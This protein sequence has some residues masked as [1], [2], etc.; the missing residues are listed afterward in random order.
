M[1]NQHGPGQVK[2]GLGDSNLFAERFFEKSL[3]HDFICLY[4]Y[5]CICII[6]FYI[7]IVIL[8]GYTRRWLDTVQKYPY[9]MIW[10]G[11]YCDET[12]WLQYMY[13]FFV[14][15]QIHNMYICVYTYLYTQ[16]YSP[17]AWWWRLVVYYIGISKPPTERPINARTQIMK[18]YHDAIQGVLCCLQKIRRRR[19][20]LRTVR[21]SCVVAQGLI[22]QSRANHALVKYIFCTQSWS[23]GTRHP[24]RTKTPHRDRLRLSQMSLVQRRCVVWWNHTFQISKPQQKCG[25]KKSNSWQLPL[26]YILCIYIY[27][28]LF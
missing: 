9:N 24:W 16:H 1:E 11:L 10:Y 5:V 25:V 26:V 14:C 15:I 17:C 6:Y 28:D 2:K 13:V 27:R 8:T 23:A 12:S 21:P 4:V 7:H 18:S 22:V 3:W 19:S 20:P